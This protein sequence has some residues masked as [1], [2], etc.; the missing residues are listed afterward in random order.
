M[1]FRLLYSETA[2]N[3]IRHLHPELKSIIRSKLNELTEDPY[4]GKR[5]E[6]DL[7]G[8]WSLPARRFR[9]VYIV[10]EDSKTVEIYYASHRRDMY[11]LI[12]GEL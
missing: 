6:R 9:I 2:R 10:A 11:E 4:A 1:R 5:L 8:F 3:Q 7:S 12:R